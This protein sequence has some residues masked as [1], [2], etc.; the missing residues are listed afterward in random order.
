MLARLNTLRGQLNLWYSR[1][2]SYW[3]QM[4]RDDLVKDVDRNTKYFQPVASI[5]KRKKLMVEIQKGRKM[6]RDPRSI[7]GEVR[8]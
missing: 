8:R 4:S 7:K 1:K 5:K 6:L 2:E 3:T